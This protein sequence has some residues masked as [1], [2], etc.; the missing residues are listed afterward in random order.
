MSDNNIGDGIS[1]F[2]GDWTF[3]GETSANFDKRVIRSV[4]LYS[5]GHKLICHVSDFF[6]SR[7]SL[8]MS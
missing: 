5:E 8:F 6:L 2:I 4:P 3:S 1:T 7:D